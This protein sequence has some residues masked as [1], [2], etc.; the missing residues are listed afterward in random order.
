MIYPLSSMKDIL[1]DI[2]AIERQQ[3]GLLDSTIDDI[4]IVTMTREDYQGTT[5]DLL[6]AVL[7]SV[8]LFS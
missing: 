7:N 2:I 8:L 5:S 3:H 4:S 6:I 1:H